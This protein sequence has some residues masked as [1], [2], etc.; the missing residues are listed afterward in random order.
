ML[1]INDAVLPI[2]RSNK[3]L[4]DWPGQKVF[5]QELDAS[6]ELDEGLFDDPFIIKF[7]SKPNSRV[8]MLRDVFRTLKY[9]RQNIETPLFFLFGNN[10]PKR[11]KSICTKVK[12]DAL[13]V[14][15]QIKDGKLVLL[16]LG[17]R[18]VQ[19]DLFYTYFENLSPS[20]PDSYCEQLVVDI[21]HHLK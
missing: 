3:V 12:K 8:A 13:H 19:N 9:Y 7:I 4:R 11:I 16:G 5:L 14:S 21:Q 17:E 2:V 20:L 6:V 18:I 1:I 10:A 15:S